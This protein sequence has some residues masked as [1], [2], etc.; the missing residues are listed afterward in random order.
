MNQAISLIDYSVINTTAEKTKQIKP[1]PRHREV[2]CYRLTQN[3]LNM[4][5]LQRSNLGPDLRYPLHDSY[6]KAGVH[7]LAIENL[8]FNPEEN[9]LSPIAAEDLVQIACTNSDAG[10]YII[11]NHYFASRLSSKNLT[12]IAISSMRCLLAILSKPQLLFCL[13]AVDLEQVLRM[14]RS[15]RKG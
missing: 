7:L 9:Q 12:Q 6:Y 2:A 4:Q 8:H 5:H 1:E 10:L 15:R 13:E 3:L 14:R 11:N